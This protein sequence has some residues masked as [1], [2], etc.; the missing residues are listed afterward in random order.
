MLLDA[1]SITDEGVAEA[2]RREEKTGRKLACRKGCSACCRTHTTIPVYP[3]ELTG[4]TWYATERVQ[5]PHREKLKQRLKRYKESSVC[6]FLI[7]DDC[8]IYPLRPMACRQFNVFDRACDRGEDAYYTRRQDVLT[9]IEKYTDKAFN[10]MLPFYGAKTRVQRRQ[11]IKSR[12]IHTKAIPMLS[13]NWPS[14]ADKM[15]EYEKQQPE[16]LK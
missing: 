16:A 11:V 3:L 12:V 13:C 9:P 15:E 10:V 8:S 6:P 4:I 1:Y 7:D 5:A 14:L 2:I